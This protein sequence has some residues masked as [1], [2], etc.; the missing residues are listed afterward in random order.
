MCGFAINRNTVE[1]DFR[2]QPPVQAEFLFAIVFPSF[3]AGKIQKAQIQGLLDL[4]GIIAGQ[5][6]MR[7]MGLQ[8]LDS[9]DGMRIALWP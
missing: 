4:V 8:V 1:I 5:Q 6:D 7:D 3:Q 9:G 2:R